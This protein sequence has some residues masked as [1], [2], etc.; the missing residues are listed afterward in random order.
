M[1]YTAPFALAALTAIIS[2]GH[3]AEK[4]KHWRQ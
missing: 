3:A 1:N 4:E 2:S